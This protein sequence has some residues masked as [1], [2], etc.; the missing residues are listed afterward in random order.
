[1]TE[2]DEI[3]E[4]LM[5]SSALGVR[6]EVMR[7]AKE[8]ITENP[9]IRKVDAYQSAYNYWFMYQYEKNING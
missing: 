9:N 2:S 5:E 6:E 8:I 7:S 3:E 4:I 1:M